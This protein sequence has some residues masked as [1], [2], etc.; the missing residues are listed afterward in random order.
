MSHAHESPFARGEPRLPR[1][2]PRGLFSQ[3][4][5]DESLPT[6]QRLSRVYRV[7]AALVGICLVVFGLLGV[8]SSIGFWSNGDDTVVG[9]HTDGA[10][11][12]LSILVGLVLFSGMIKGGNFASNLNLIVGLLFLLSGFVN[13]AVIRT[14]LNFLNFRIANVIFSFVVGL[15][16][17]VFGMYGRVSG[18]LPHDNPYFRA[19]NP[20]YEVEA[21][22]RRELSERRQQEFSRGQAPGRPPSRRPEAGR[23]ETR[24]GS[25]RRF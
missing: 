19:R 10:L 22:R 18:R 9:L 24:R 1:N 23:R 11:S 20:E 3:A 16:L 8:F 2:T 7:G 17:L 4:R 13:L 14:P 5:L 6:D 15:L 25:P 21:A 12:W